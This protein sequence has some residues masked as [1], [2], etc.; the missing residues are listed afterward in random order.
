MLV[1]AVNKLRTEKL[2][3]KPYPIA[4]AVVL[5]LTFV[6]VVLASVTSLFY[7]P[8]DL[9][10]SSFTMWMAVLAVYTN[11]VAVLIFVALAWKSKNQ[12]VEALDEATNGSQDGLM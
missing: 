11:C 4:L 8:Q 9:E 2:V 1:H 5:S 12:M 6:F 10:K 7:L 3:N